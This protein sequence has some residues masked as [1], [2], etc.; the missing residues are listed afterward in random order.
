[1]RRLC[2]SPCFSSDL[3]IWP[4]RIV[5]P[6]SKARVNRSVHFLH[7]V[8]AIV[9]TSSFTACFRRSL[10]GGIDGPG[11]ALT[12]CVAWRQFR[13]RA[14]ER[15]KNEQLLKDTCFRG[16]REYGRN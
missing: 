15:S 14:R 8:A 9:P 1:M 3:R 6:D 12:D 16:S 11:V 2:F 7:S 10:L 13:L 5:F 4:C